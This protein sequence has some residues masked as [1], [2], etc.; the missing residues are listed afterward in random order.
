MQRVNSELEIMDLPDLDCE[1]Y[2]E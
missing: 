1:L 2:Q